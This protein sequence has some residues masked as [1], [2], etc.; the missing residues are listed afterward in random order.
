MMLIVLF[1]S[2]RP[3]LVFGRDA[4]FHFRVVAF[5]CVFKPLQ[6]RCSFLKSKQ[7]QCLVLKCAFYVHGYTLWSHEMHISGFTPRPLRHESGAIS[8]T[9]YSYQ[10]GAMCDGVFI[11]N[12]TSNGRTMK[13]NIKM[14]ITSV[15]SLLLGQKYHIYFAMVYYHSVHLG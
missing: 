14:G 13:R 12:K 3:V 4:P 6:L 8:C 11:A 9:I 15:T 1:N 7:L 10:N 2:Q 5:K